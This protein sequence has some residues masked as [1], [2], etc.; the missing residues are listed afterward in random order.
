MGHEMQAVGE[1]DA[2]EYYY[3]GYYYPH[4]PVLRH[5]RPYSQEHR[6]RE[7]ERV[8]SKHPY[9][10]RKRAHGILACICLDCCCLVGFNA[11]HEGESA[12]SVFEVLYT[13][14]PSAPDMV[15]YDNACNLSIYCH[16]R[17]SYFFRNSSFVIDKL[18]HWNHF[19]CS[20]AFMFDLF[21]SLIKKNS[22][23]VEQLW[24]R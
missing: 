11:L 22:Q 5:C 20:P 10:S 8:C 3:T 15:V 17:E 1:Y 21:A 9:K 4:L 16:I 2:A 18:H 24:S 13:R 14:W 7:L 19:E 12:R 6:A 23:L